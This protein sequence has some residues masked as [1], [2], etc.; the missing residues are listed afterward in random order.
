M[1]LSLFINVQTT[2]SLLKWTLHKDDWWQTW[3]FLLCEIM[4]EMLVVED[5]FPLGVGDRLRDVTDLVHKL[6]PTTSRV[7]IFY[8]MNSL[9]QRSSL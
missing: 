6:N 3:V 1:S 4:C 5:F 7:T 8:I 9:V 2:T